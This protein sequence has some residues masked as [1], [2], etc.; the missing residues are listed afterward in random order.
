MVTVPRSGIDSE[1]TVLPS[2]TPSPS[3]VRLADDPQVSG[4]C[5]VARQGAFGASPRRASANHATGACARPPGHR[6]PPRS[7]TCQRRPNADPAEARGVCAQRT[8]GLVAVAGS[9]C[10]LKPISDGCVST[11]RAA[12]RICSRRCGS[13]HSLAQRPARALHPVDGPRRCNRPVRSRWPGR[14]AYGSRRW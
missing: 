11:E 4:I 7:E 6:A 1:R 13:A 10:W 3:G 2:V 5:A 12:N 8:C 14:L 9:R